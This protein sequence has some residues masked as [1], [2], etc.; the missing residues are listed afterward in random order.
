MAVSVR[1]ARFSHRLVCRRTPMWPCNVARHSSTRRAWPAISP[2]RITISFHS[3]QKYPADVTLPSAATG[4]IIKLLTDDSR[5][6]VVVY[7]YVSV[8]L[9]VEVNRS[10]G[11]HFSLAF[12]RIPS[13][14]LFLS[15]HLPTPVPPSFPS[16]LCLLSSQLYPRLLWIST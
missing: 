2:P 13:D 1:Q 14:F 3:L 6:F 9:S 5:L 7:A 4:K 16:S 11:R 10:R 12:P 8:I 15:S